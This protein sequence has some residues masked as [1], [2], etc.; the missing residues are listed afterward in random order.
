MDSPPHLTI[1]AAVP[2]D[3]AAIA[4]MNSLPGFRFGTLRLPHT[5]PADVSKWLDR[6]DDNSKDL[7]ALSEDRVIGIAGLTRHPGRR[8]HAG[9]IGMGVHDDWT[10]QGI[11]TRLLGELLDYAD[12]WLGLRRIELTV[13]TD[14]APAVA[15]YRKHG[16]VVEGCHRRFALRDGVFAD[17]YFT[18]RLTG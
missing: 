6:A 3:A 14:N 4:A 18:A 15:L 17:A 12:N 11:G 9:G 16:F 13:F 2:S 10:G 7:V 1:R 8:S 5:R